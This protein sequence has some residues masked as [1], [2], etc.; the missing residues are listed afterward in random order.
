MKAKLILKVG[1]LCILAFIARP[2]SADVLYDN[3]NVPSAGADLVNLTWGPLA[4]SFSTGSGGFILQ[5]V[6]LLLS[7]GNTSTG[8]IAVTLLSENSITPGSPA[9]SH[10]SEIRLAFNLRQ[11]TFVSSERH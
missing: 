2:V 5:D 6:K 11:A 7:G 4:D 10:H 9:P 3:L 8:S 1:A